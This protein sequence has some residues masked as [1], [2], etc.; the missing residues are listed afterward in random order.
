MTSDPAE[1]AP[2]TKMESL[3]S[4]RPDHGIFYTQSGLRCLNS[5]PRDKAE[6][7]TSFCRDSMFLKEG[8]CNSKL[9]R[10]DIFEHSC[11]FCVCLEG[12]DEVVILFCDIDVCVYFDLSRCKQDKMYLN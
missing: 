10:S 6:V 4:Y 5:G 9:I 1:T 3:Y 2:L 8:M 11:F 12:R 7:P